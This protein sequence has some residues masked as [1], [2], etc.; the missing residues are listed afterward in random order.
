M[1]QS[2]FVI[3]G[4]LIFIKLLFNKWNVWTIFEEIGSESKFKFIYKLTNCQFCLLFWFSIIITIIYG[5]AN[6]FTWSLL[7]APFVVNGLI[8]LIYQK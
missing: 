8:H 4:L 5:I 2:I 1:L 7:I 6:G 3:L